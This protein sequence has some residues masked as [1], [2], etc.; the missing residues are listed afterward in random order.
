MS[1]FVVT[2]E[3]REPPDPARLTVLAFV[4]AP[5]EAA[6]EQGAHAALAERQWSDVRWL[7]TGEVT[8]EAAVPEDFS[9][10]MASA[11]RFGLGLIIYEEP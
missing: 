4:E 2:L 10:A 3:G 11:R 1:I 8:D 5:D 6:A 7:R 9:R